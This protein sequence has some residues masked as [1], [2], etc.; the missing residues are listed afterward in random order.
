MKKLLESGYGY[1]TKVLTVSMRGT[2][3]LSFWG[4]A[5]P[6]WW[7]GPSWGMETIQHRGAFGSQDKVVICQADT[8]EELEEQLLVKACQKYHD[9]YKLPNGEDVRRVY[10]KIYE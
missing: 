2:H 5:C 3:I 6:L 4:C 9:P 8:L 7:I 10:P 1:L